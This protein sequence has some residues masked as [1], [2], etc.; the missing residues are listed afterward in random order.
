VL[1][2]RHRFRVIY[3]D[4]DMMGVV[5]YATYLRYFEAGRN[6]LLRTIGL[7]YRELE[8]SGIML[9]VA[10]VEVAYKVPA[11]YD[12]ELELETTLAEVRHASATI[13]YRLTRAKDEELIATGETVHACIGRDGRVTRFPP[14]IRAGLGQ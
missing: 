3:G 8:K 12:D 11:R 10:S 6:E 2:N 9:P 5:Y 1:S 4:T 14:A 13:S 7:P